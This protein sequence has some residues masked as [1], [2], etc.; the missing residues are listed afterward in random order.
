MKKVIIIIYI[1][2]RERRHS[3]YGFYSTSYN[4]FNWAPYD[5]SDTNNLH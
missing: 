2:L 5:E 4:H 3:C 1:D